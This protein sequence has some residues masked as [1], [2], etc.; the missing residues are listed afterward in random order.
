MVTRQQIIDEA[1]TFID[2]PFHHQGRV[3]SIGVDCAGVVGMVGVALGLLN[4]EDLPK[5][6]AKQPN[7]NQMTKVL[8]EKMDRIPIHEA[9][10]GDVYHFAFDR[11][12]QHVG[13]ITDI[14]ILHAYAQVRKCVEHSL[15]DT[16]QKRI[17]G[18]YRFKGIV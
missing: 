7:A 6:Y 1:R 11:E 2:T 17:R 15:D 14:G 9:T 18:A 4:I 8:D 13:I 5:D 3:K 12:P 10:I 16:W